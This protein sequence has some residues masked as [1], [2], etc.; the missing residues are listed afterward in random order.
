MWGP[1]DLEICWGTSQDLA[2][3]AKSAQGKGAWREAR[4]YGHTFLEP[5]PVG[6]YRTCPT[7]QAGAV[8]TCMRYRPPHPGSLSEVS[9]QSFYWDHVMWATSAWLVPEFQT[10][11]KSGCSAQ[12]IVF[13]QF[14]ASEALS[15]GWKPSPNPHSQTPPKGPCCQQA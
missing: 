14:M 12:A 2:H 3:R 5:C 4:G 7:P 8:T 6:S 1:Q 11:R 13:V 15:H 10:P 9:T